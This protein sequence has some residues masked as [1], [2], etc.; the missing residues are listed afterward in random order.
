MKLFTVGK[1]PAYCEAITHRIEHRKSGAAK[2]VDLA[3]KIDPFTTQLAG[4]MDPG[5]YGYVRRLLF[6]MGDATPVRELRSVE[7]KPPADRQTI[8]CFATTDSPKPSILFDQVKVTK[9]RVRGHKD[10][11]GWAFYLY[12]SFGPLGKTELEYVNAFYTEQRFLTLDAAEPSLEFDEEPDEDEDDQ[13]DESPD[14]GRLPGHDFET[15]A[16]GEPVDPE[17]FRPLQDLLKEAGAV[18]LLDQVAAWTVAQREQ[19]H[20]WATAQIQATANSK[21]GHSVSVRWPAH[22]S[23]ASGSRVPPTAK[24]ERAHRPLH[25][26]QSK[27][28]GTRKGRR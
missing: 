20:A 3:L 24:P 21:P 14:Q 8:R 11:D 4:A 27:K 1:V 12:V 19:A 28:Q 22:V 25:S 10:G 17:T 23:A 16:D 15:T 26:H 7:L 6:K 13:K 18:I 5:E 2:V 9:L